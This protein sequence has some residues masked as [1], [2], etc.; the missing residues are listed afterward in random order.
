MPRLRQVP[1]AEVTSPVVKEWYDLLFGP[2]RDPERWPSQLALSRNATWVLDPA[3]A[4]GLP[5]G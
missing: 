1:R 4:A 5:R 2:E 3:A